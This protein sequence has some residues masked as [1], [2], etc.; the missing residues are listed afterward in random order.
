MVTALV[1]I[2]QYEKNKDLSFAESAAEACINVIE[3]DPNHLTATKNLAKVY[4]IMGEYN[5]EAKT[6]K[7]ASELTTS[8]K[9]KFTYIGASY[10]ATGRAGDW[11]RASSLFD[12]LLEEVTEEQAE[13]LWGAAAQA[14]INA[15][16]E[17][18]ARHYIERLRT[19]GYEDVAKHLEKGLK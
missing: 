18:K 15:G 9:D 16:R 17:D 13:Q 3:I 2:N 7:A 12:L 11:T 6:W 5:A 8:T 19:E 14:A 4:R 10:Q 1:C